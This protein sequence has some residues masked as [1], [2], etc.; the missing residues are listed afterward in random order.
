MVRD[1]G[2]LALSSL[3]IAVYSGSIAV[4]VER[5]RLPE[6]P[7]TIRGIDAVVLCIFGLATV[8]AVGLWRIL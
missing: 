4:I 8:G 2:A 5:I 3:I 6:H 7:A 1:D